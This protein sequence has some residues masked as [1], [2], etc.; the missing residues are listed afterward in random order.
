MQPRYNNQCLKQQ[1]EKLI[2]QS[3]QLIADSKELIV[4]A[5]ELIADSQELNLKIE[6]AS[7]DL[8]CFYTRRKGV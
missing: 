8:K 2:A 1:G 5:Q 4:V 3:E 6:N 7:Q